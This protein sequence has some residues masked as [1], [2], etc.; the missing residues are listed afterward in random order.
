[1]LLLLGCEDQ[2][3]GLIMPDNVDISVTDN[4]VVPIPSD[5][6]TILISI[7]SRYSKV[8]APNG[9]PIHI[10]AQSEVSDQQSI[11]ARDI[12]GFYA[13]ACMICQRDS[14]GAGECHTGRGFHKDMDDGWNVAPHC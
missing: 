13:H 11:R 14:T 1:M 2:P 9:K 7:F 4:G 8:V 10:F 5:V 6:D 3:K 12:L